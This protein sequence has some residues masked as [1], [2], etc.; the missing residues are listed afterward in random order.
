LWV[1][2]VATVEVDQRATVFSVDPRCLVEDD[3]LAL[4]A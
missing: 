4:L 1:E 3:I 2:C